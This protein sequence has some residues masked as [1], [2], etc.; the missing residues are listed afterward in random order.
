MCKLLDLIK[1]LGIELRIVKRADKNI[2][3]TNIYP[4]EGK[5][6]EEFLKLSSALESALEGWYKRHGEMLTCRLE[7]GEIRDLGD[8][9]AELL[10]GRY[11]ELYCY[12]CSEVAFVR[13]WLEAGTFYKKTWI[14][15]DIDV[16]ENSLWFSDDLD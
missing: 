16:V 7:S 11:F 1:D 15:L 8:S 9:Q 12:E 2:A 10:N 13:L 6:E 14:S 5:E 4:E 3:T